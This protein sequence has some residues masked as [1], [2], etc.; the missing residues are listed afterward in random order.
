M[1]RR[2]P[3]LVHEPRIELVASMVMSPSE[4]MMPSADAR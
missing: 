1:C 4:A 3:R 2:F